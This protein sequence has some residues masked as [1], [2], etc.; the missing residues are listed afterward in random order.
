[1]ASSQS[2]SAAGR[3][4]NNALPPL[5]EITVDIPKTPA[6]TNTNETFSTL[7]ENVSPATL[8]AERS[9]THSHERSLSAMSSSSKVFPFSNRSRAPSDATLLPPA[10]STSASIHSGVSGVSKFTLDSQRHDDALKPDP[11]SEKDFTIQ[12]NKFAFS[13]GQ[14]NKML[15][16]KSLGAFIALGGLPGLEAGLRTDVDAG[17]SLEETDL[18]GSVSF[19]EATTMY[20]KLK[21]TGASGL[22]RPVE[23]RHV[24]VTDSG[25]SASGSKPGEAFGDRK[26]V[27]KTN[28]LP[29]K[30]PKSFLKL[31]WEAYYKESVLI[32]LTVAAVISLALGLYET[33]GVDHGP[34]APPPVDWIE[35]CAICVSI[36]VVVLVGAINDWQKERAFVRLNAKKEA[37]EV[38]VIRSGKSFN[39]SV[40]DILVG[41]VMHMEPG[42]L[43]PAD[44]VF[45][46]GH[47]V[48]C[49]ESSA[50]GESDQMKKTSAE[51]VLRLLE[52]GHNDSKD[53]DPFIISGS[54][55]LEGVG[56]CRLLSHSCEI[57][58][59]HQQILL[60]R[61]ELTLA[62][63]VSSWLCDR[64]WSQHLSK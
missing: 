48:K 49:D 4:Q 16:P 12:N 61:S 32:L 37:R 23:V 5:P 44:G 11:G 34:G 15:N 8:V 31:M 19:E 29:T 41:D 45:I 18:A 46:S 7:T 52:R 13:P 50:T 20:K 28:V 27:F 58:N 10:T 56:T 64:I 62:T 30:K 22:P 55:V 35:G 47:N 25:P 42:D 21:G 38:K 63:V 26:R 60:H 2:S 1:M 6:R 39:I 3:E 54:K 17:L 9:F 59:L 53:L 33:F 36:A 14:L 24:D 43:I 40:Y 57:P 51:Q